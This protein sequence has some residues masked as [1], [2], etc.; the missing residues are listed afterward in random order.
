VE[1][2]FFVSPPQAFRVLEAITLSR[3]PLNPFSGCSS[4]VPARA[5]TLVKEINDY[6]EFLFRFSYGYC[7]RVFA[8]RLHDPHLAWPPE[9]WNFFLLAVRHAGLELSLMDF[10]SLVTRVFAVPYLPRLDV[11]FLKP[12]PAPVLDLPRG[13]PCFFFF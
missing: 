7:T 8:A 12:K 10:F 9:N 11:F 2:V 3:F 4:S 1:S 13:T 6:I 5:R